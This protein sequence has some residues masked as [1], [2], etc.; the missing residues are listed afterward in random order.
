MSASVDSK[1]SPSSRV[2]LS[3]VTCRRSYP[4]DW[5]QRKRDITRLRVAQRHPCGKPEHGERA[6]FSSFV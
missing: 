3:T 5:Q 6:A 4:H 2:S 1:A